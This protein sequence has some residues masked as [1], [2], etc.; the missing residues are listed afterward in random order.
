MTLLIAVCILA[1]ILVFKTCL[2]KKIESMGIKTSAAY[3]KLLRGI[4]SSPTNRKFSVHNQDRGPGDFVIHSGSCSSVYT[5]KTREVS[6]S[7]EDSRIGSPAADRYTSF[8]LPRIECRMVS[9][10]VLYVRPRFKFYFLR[11]AILY[12]IFC[13][14]SWSI[15]PT[16]E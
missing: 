16:S 15:Q 2:L 7:P 13:D 1:R 8:L 4:W 11:Q 6:S 5:N 10:S 14:Y 12:I 3:W 9:T